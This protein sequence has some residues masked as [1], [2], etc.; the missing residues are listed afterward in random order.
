M[1]GPISLKDCSWW[2]LISDKLSIF[3]I[4]T[5][6]NK[7]KK[8]F[9]KTLW[10]QV[11]LFK[12]SNFTFFHNV[13]CAVCIL[14]SFISHIPVVGCNFFEFATVSKWCFFMEWVKPYFHR[15]RLMVGYFAMVLLVLFLLA[16]IHI[17]ILYSENL[18]KT[19]SIEKVHRILELQRWKSDCMFL[20]V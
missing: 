10:K 7:R 15:A 19:E 13:F 11:K 5:H 3:S 2:I 8:S 18:S 16:F 9:G 6:F 20:V 1:S 14:K 12:T 17:F 4:Y